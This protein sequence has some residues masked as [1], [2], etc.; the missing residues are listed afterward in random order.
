MDHELHDWY[1][2]LCFRICSEF[3]EEL[4]DLVGFGQ[5]PP[6][7]RDSRKP[8]TCFSFELHRAVL[9]E[10]RSV[11]D[12]QPLFEFNRKA[13]LDIRKCSKLADLAYV[14]VDE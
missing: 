6:V 11:S 14:I 4:D 8:Q 12:F 3:R 2:R 1:I 5:W 10:D 9:R 13:C 7:N